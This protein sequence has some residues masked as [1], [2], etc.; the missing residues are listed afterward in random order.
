MINYHSG[1]FPANTLFK[2]KS[3]LPA[4]FEAQ[5]HLGEKVWVNQRCLV[6]TATFYHGAQAS[7]LGGGTGKMMAP[8]STLAYGNRDTYIKGLQDIIQKPIL[9]MEQEFA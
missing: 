2:L 3:V 4:P 8:V 5:N 9:T 6:V 7:T 1:L